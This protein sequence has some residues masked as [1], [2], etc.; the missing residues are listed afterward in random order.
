MSAHPPAH[1]VPEA[2][3]EDLSEQGV[4]DDHFITTKLPR[5]CGICVI[6][7]TLALWAAMVGVWLLTSVLLA[8]GAYAHE[9]LPT[10]AQP[11]GW[12]YPMSCCWSPQT[13]PAGRA[14]DCSQIPSKSAKAI[15]GGYSVTLH[16]GEHPMVKTPLNTVV[17]Y[18]KTRQSPDNE[19]HICFA[20]DMSVRCFFAPP[21]GV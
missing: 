11:E 10:A 14:G 5:F 6:V 1:E 12:S 19:Y 16:E 18:P 13:A 2:W 7:A 9:A 3:H 4:A 17:P 15:E 8:S 20:P 21:P